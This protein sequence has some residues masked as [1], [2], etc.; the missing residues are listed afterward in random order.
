MLNLQCFFLHPALTEQW[1]YGL[2]SDIL[3]DL[4]CACSLPVPTSRHYHQPQDILSFSFGGFETLRGALPVSNQGQTQLASTIALSFRVCLSFFRYHSTPSI[5]GNT[6]DHNHRSNAAS[7]A[8]DATFPL[9]CAPCGLSTGPR[10]SYHQGQ[11]PPH[12]SRSFTLDP[13]E[14]PRPIQRRA[15]T[16]Y[17]HDRSAILSVPREP[18]FADLVKAGPPLSPWSKAHPNCLKEKYRGK[19][20]QS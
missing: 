5:L 4:T 6:S 8:T 9:F 15:S 12:D 10:S 1:P 17:F 13:A 3:F 16:S 14:G 2:S 11:R 20:S 18:T 7:V 19:K